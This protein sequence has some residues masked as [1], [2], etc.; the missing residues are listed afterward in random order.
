MPP[1]SDAN[2][3]TI[4]GKNMSIMLERMTSLPTSA[5]SLPAAP[6]PVPIETALRAIR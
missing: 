6:W 2:A 4:I 3:M 1:I 5:V